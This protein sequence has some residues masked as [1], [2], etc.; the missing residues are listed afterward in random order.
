MYP[1]EKL[2]TSLPNLNWR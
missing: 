1:T 2:I